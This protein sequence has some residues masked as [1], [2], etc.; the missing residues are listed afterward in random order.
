M[1]SHESLLRGDLAEGKPS[2]AVERLR[3]RPSVRILA[4]MSQNTF[5]KPGRVETA[6]ARLDKAMDRLEQALAKKA[7]LAAT[8]ALANAAKPDSGIAPEEFAAV[9]SENARLRAANENVSE[10]LD[11]TIDRLEKI[12]SE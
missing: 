10:R 3:R 5:K 9:Q 12:L 1:C 6:R 11:A 4:V 7:G 8:D 2:C